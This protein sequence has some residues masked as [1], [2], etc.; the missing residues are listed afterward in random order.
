MNISSVVIAVIQLLTMILVSYMIFADLRYT[1][2]KR[3]SKNW[4][5][6]LATIDSAR[7]GFRGPFSGIPR[8][9]YRVHFI[10]SYEAGG[11]KRNG[12]FFILVRSKEGGEDLERAVVGRKVIIK[13]DDRNPNVALLVDRELAGK[14]IV[15]GPS[16][17]YR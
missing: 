12:R 10:Y 17:T 3:A 6:T 15:Q 13:Y 5:T 8:I 1:L 11:S 7:V 2:R 16:W 14:R 9:F 4:P